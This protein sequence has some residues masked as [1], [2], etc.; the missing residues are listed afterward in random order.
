M[1]AQ[2]S[3]T[4]PTLH[5]KAV[6]ERLQNLQVQD[7]DDYVEVISDAE[8]SS[9]GPLIRDAEGL[10]LHVLESWQAAIIKDPKNK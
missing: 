5:E 6:L 1:G 9:I 7:Q 8:K 4:E 2:Q 3:K 10:P